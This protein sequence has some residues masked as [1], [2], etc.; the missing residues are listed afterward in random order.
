[1]NIFK[2]EYEMKLG[3]DGVTPVLLRPTMEALSLVESSI[4]SLAYLAWKFAV[5]KAQPKNSVSF[6]D[7]V[8]IIYHCQAR[9]NKDDRNKPEFSLEEIWAMA[10]DRGL[11]QVSAEM[12]IFVSMVTSGDQSAPEASENAKKN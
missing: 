7:V 9:R 5:S 11:F 12:I 3:K 2:N 4:G 1:M 10:Q 6:T 8:K